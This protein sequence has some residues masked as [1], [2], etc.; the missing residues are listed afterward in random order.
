[1]RDC[2]TIDG[3]IDGLMDHM[4]QGNNLKYYCS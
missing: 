4:K 3:W 2:I 1:M